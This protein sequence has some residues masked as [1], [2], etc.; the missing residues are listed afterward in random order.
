MADDTT[1]YWAIVELMGHRRLAGRLTEVTLAGA[2]FL[3]I[4]IPGAD[5][6]KWAATQFIS[7]SSGS[8]YAI[9]PVSEEVAR[10]AARREQPQPVHAWELPRLEHQ[11][12]PSGPFC[13]ELIIGEEDEFDAP[14]R[15]CGQPAEWNDGDYRCAQ[16]VAARR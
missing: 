1:S 15:Q 7:P 14:G 9:T 5:P 3:R 11:P 13:A 2:G 10:V 12:T 8:I 6:E 4:D 16:H